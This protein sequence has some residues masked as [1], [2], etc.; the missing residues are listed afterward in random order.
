MKRIISVLLSAAVAAGM[1]VSCGEMEDEPMRDMTT[2]EIV[3]EM[4]IGINLGNTFDCHGDWY[5]GGGTVED[6]QTAWGS[7]VIT[8]EI[9]QSYVDAGFGVMRLP[10]S[11][12]S[13]MDPEGNIDK[14]LLDNVEKVVRW[15]LD[16]DMYCILNMHHESWMDTLGTDY[17]A[18][19]A[20][21]E[22]VWTQIAERFKH[23]GDKLMFESMNEV[24]VD[25]LWNRFG[26]GTE[27]KEEAFNRHNSV[28]QKFVDIVRASGANNAKRHLLIA[29]YWTDIDLACDPLTKMPNDPEGRIAVSVHYYTPSTLCLLDSDADW[30]KAKT[31]WG[32]EEDYATLHEKMDMM[33]ENYV[34]KGIPVIIGEYGCFGYNKPAE[35]KQKWTLDVATEAYERDMC[36]IL[37]DT[38]GGEQFM[39][40]ELRWLHKDFIAELVGIAKK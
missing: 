6:L 33:T 17:E 12:Q 21:Y 28:N 3:K 20:K 27:G 39:R 5:S 26:G 34:K 18:T 23:Y 19:M 15:I 24:G 1:L 22:K 38:P 14:S 25:S 16:G 8:Q 11:W 2:A 9:I 31:D 30:G 40:D 37:W 29:T 36:P 32:S 35:I 10:V 4:G 13:L 7:P